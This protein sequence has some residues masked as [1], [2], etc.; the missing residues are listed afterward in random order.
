MKV[1]N[2]LATAVFASILSLAGTGF[3]AEVSGK[4]TEVKNEGRSVMIGDKE[5]K[6]SGSRTKVKVKGEDAGRDAIKAGMSCEANVE[7][8]Q[9]QTISCK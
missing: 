6:I 7:G 2:V 9:A 5:V 4:V 8:D 1:T 3:A